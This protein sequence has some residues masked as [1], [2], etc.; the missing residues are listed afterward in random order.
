MRAVRDA[1]GA[2]A[3]LQRLKCKGEGLLRYGS[4]PKNLR[5]IVFHR[6]KGNWNNN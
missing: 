3:G 2:M 4:T 5:S 6:L 1:D